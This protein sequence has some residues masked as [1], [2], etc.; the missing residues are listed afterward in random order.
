MRISIWQQFS[1]N[2]S[3]SFT[4]VGVFETPEAARRAA[5]EVRKIIEPVLL[6][7]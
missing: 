3:S 7:H 1:I 6:M 5:D 4:V 2:N